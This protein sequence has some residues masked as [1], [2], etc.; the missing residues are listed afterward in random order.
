[1]SS[2]NLT[3]EE[4]AYYKKR[5]SWN[6]VQLFFGTLLLVMAYIHLQD[7]TAEKMSISSGVQV[8]SQK[9]QLWMHNLWDHDGNI[10]QEKLDME[11]SYGEVVNVVQNSSC[12]EK[13]DAQALVNKYNALQNESV[14]EYTNNSSE[15]NKFLVDFYRKITDVC[16]SEV[17]TQQ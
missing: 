11:K 3:A 6:I 14:A 4:K 7:S 16:Q 8:I 15:Y 2:R 5:L 17:H 13:V 12:K 1:M 9:V 10:Y